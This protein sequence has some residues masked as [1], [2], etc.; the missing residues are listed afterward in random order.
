M[1]QDPDPTSSLASGSDP[2]LPPP[3]PQESPAN[4]GV[5]PRPADPLAHRRAEP[6]ALAL[7][8]TGYLLVVT[9][10]S[11]VDLGAVGMGS[12]DVFRHA[13]RQMLTLVLAGI[14]LVWPMIR[15][16]Q[17]APPHPIRGTLL[18][19]LVIGS[20]SVAIGLAQSLAGMSAWPL[21]VM[22]AWVLFALGWGLLVS[23]VIVSGLRGLLS[24]SMAMAIL[25]GLALAGPALDMVVDGRISS[26]ADIDLIAMF[27]PFS[28]TYE[29]T[30]DRSWI[31]ETAEV[32]TVHWSV[33]T[34]LFTLG[35]TAL[36][37]QA[38]I[39]NT[40]VSGISRA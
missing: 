17:Q 11:T 15:L 4:L 29:L 3:V 2:S 38:L 37:S 9:F 20:P 25:I 31:G 36:V 40:L 22:S 8:W 13:A 26:P 30:R 24:R 12:H 23:G 5:A 39:R 33:L 10:I 1:N 34:L 16:S 7:M 27:S 14:A 18:D 19:L 21:N 32:N 35:A 28:V 6:R